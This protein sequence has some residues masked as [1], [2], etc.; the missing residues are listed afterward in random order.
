MATYV[1]QLRARGL[2]GVSYLTL[3]SGISLR[4]VRLYSFPV[5]PGGKEIEESTE[6]AQSHKVHHLLV[7]TES[8]CH[9]SD[10][11][12]VYFEWQLQKRKEEGQ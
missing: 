6:L 1:N 7:S 9:R 11:V 12:P 10:F 8:F 5:G 3:Y 4:N 2:A